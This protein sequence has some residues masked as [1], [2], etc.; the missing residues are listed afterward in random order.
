MKRTSM[1]LPEDREEKLKKISRMFEQ[2]TYSKSIDIAL[3]ITINLFE[4]SDEF[5][6]TQLAKIIPEKHMGNFMAKKM[7]K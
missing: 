2:N 5:A 1:I 3:Q 4:H 7:V 6:R